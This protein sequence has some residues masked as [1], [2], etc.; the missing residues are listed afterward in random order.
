MFIAYALV[1]QLHKAIAAYAC[2][3]VARWRG[4]MQLY[5]YLLLVCV[6]L[7]PLCLRGYQRLSLA[8]YTGQRAIL[9]IIIIIVD[10]KTVT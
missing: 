10:I 5:I 3:C 2:V 4:Q 1:A 7:P 9:I 8:P 6:A